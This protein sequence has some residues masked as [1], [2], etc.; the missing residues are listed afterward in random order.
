Y[1]VQAFG[2]DTDNIEAA[3]RQFAMEETPCQGRQK[4]LSGSCQAPLLVAVYTGGSS[5]ISTAAPMAYF[6]KHQG[7]VV[8]RDQVDFACLAAQ[9][10]GQHDQPASLQVAAGVFLCPASGLLAG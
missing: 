4:E 5:A 10:L 3:S 6:D 7:A 8:V 1:P 2:F 9:V